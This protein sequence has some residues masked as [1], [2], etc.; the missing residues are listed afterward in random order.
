MSKAELHAA[1]LTLKAKLQAGEATDVNPFLLN[2]EG[3]CLQVN[4][5]WLQPL[6]VTHLAIK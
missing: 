2:E 3:D 4:S 5:R 1:H 6:Q